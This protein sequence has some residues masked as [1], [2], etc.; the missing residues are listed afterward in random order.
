MFYDTSSSQVYKKS[1]PKRWINQTDRTLTLRMTAS[2]TFYRCKCPRTHICLLQTSGLIRLSCYT[3]YKPYI[4]YGKCLGMN[5][6]KSF[7]RWSKYKC[8]YMVSYNKFYALFSSIQHLFCS[9]V[10]PGSSFIEVTA[11]GGVKPPN[12]VNHPS[13]SLPLS[14]F[15]LL[16]RLPLSLSF[17]SFTP[18]LQSSHLQ[19]HPSHLKLLKHGSIL[20]LFQ[21]F[22]LA[23]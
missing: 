3:S 9:G 23:F 4:F 17:L 13:L 6:W 19:C 12:L 20:S 21:H 8:V 14:Y 16:L 7:F 10:K 2:E 22:A 18:P 11:D 5:S 1:W 15:C